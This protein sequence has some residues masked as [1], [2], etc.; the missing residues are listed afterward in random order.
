MQLIGIEEHCITPDIQK[1]RQTVGFNASNDRARPR[2][3]GA[4]SSSSPFQSISS[5]MANATTLQSVRGKGN[6]SSGLRDSAFIFAHAEAPTDLLGKPRLSR[7]F[8]WLS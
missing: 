6:S 3:A 8:S 2:A 1:A 4:M 7:I 5:T